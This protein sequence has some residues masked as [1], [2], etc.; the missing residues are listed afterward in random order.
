MRAKFKSTIPFGIIG[1]GR[2]GFA[3]A[4]HLSQ[5]HKEILVIDQDECKIKK[6]QDKV[7]N[8]FVIKQLDKASLEETGIQNCETVIVC[9]GEEIQASIITVLNIIELGVPRVIAKAVSTEHG[10]V[11]QKLGAEVIYPER[12]RAVRLA[13]VL[14]NS[15]A[16]ESI[17][18]SE[19][20]SISQFKLNPCFE[21][22]TV[23]D[24]DMRNRFGL[25]IIALSS[26]GTS[27][28]EINTDY[29]FKVNDVIVVAGR[30]ENVQQFDDYL[31]KQD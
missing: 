27:T 17:H 16:L 18:L 29:R 26:D 31:R 4:E 3:L 5:Y 6:L 1:L 19:E 22:R 8:V 30:K 20:F 14:I 24:L 13:Q 9:I 12:E 25:N 28:V 10:R 7:T 23:L 2:F 21:G 11:L 15:R